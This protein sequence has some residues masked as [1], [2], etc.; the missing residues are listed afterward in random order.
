MGWG[1]STFVYAFLEG[2][3]LRVS[4]AAGGTWRAATRWNWAVLS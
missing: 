3:C 4:R 2:T 1:V